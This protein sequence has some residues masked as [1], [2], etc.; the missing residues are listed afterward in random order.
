MY[1]GGYC[2]LFIA[3]LNYWVN[4]DLRPVAQELPVAST[5]TSLA[6][7]ALPG[8]MSDAEAKSPR[9]HGARPGSRRCSQGSQA[10]VRQKAKERRF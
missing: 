6:K 3:C 9:G 8:R 2:K 7:W 4:I 1:E 5:G 10:D